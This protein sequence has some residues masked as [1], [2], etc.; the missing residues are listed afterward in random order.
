MNRAFEP[1]YQIPA[2]SSRR[3]L[4]SAADVFLDPI[5]EPSCSLP[6]PAVPGDPLL[7]VKQII[8]SF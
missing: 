7:N 5:C 1:D 4:G 3:L 2:T 8:A 6:V